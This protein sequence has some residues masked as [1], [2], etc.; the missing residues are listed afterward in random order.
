MIRC[1]DKAATSML[2]AFNALVDDGKTLFDLDYTRGEHALRELL[3]ALKLALKPALELTLELALELITTKM[4]KT[5]VR[6]L[7]ISNLQ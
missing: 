5:N 2:T 6:K 3:L 4:A 1:A 7:F